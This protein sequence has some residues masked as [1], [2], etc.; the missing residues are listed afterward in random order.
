MYRKGG[1]KPFLI[2]AT[3]TISRDIV[4]GGVFALMRFELHRSLD[5]SRHHDRK[6]NRND[7]LINIF[8][9]CFATLLSRYSVFIARHGSFDLFFQS[10]EL[11]SKYTLRNSSRC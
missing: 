9:G 5:D 4:F 6:T 8:S 11:C 10:A 1:V 3:A 7:F 2:G